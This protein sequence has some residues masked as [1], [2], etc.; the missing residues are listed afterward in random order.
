MSGI[1]GEHL[2]RRFFDE[3]LSHGNLDSLDELLHEEFADYVTEGQEKERSRSAIEEMVRTLHGV[4][5]DLEFNLHDVVAPAQDTVVVR[6]SARGLLDLWPLPQIEMRVRYQEHHFHIE[7]GRIAGI[8]TP[9]ED[10]QLA[11]T[12]VLEEDDGDFFHRPPGP[13]WV[14]PKPR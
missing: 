9:P 6:W 13:P 5:S 11:A 2:V 3:V 12:V 4:V 14:P 8:W 10:G 7:R 1:D